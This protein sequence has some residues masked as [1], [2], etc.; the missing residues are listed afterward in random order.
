MLSRRYRRAPQ[1]RIFRIFFYAIAA[2]LLLDGLTILKH[3][4]EF[5]V[6]LLSHTYIEPSTLPTPAKDQKIFICA[7][8]WT[9]AYVIHTRWGDA[10]IDLIETLGADNV[11]VSIYE[12]GS[13]DNTKEILAYLDSRLAAKNIAR[14]ITLDPETHA[15]VIN[16]GPY[17]EKGDPRPGWVLP[18]SGSEGKEIR[19]IPYLA[20]TRNLSL[21]PLIEEKRR[22]RTYDKILFLN[23]IVF[24]PSDVVS[25]LA[26]NGG[27]YSVACALDFHYPARVATYYDTFALRDSNGDGTLSVQ[28]PYFRSTESRDAIWRGDSARVQSCWNG[29]TLMDATPFYNSVDG[30]GDSVDGLRFRGVSDSLASKHLE[31]SECCL[32]HADLTAMGAAEHGIY[33]NPAVRVGYTEEAYNFTHFGPENTFISPT[34]YVLAKWLYRLNRLRT[35]SAEKQMKTVHRRVEKWKKESSNSLEKRE[36]QGEMCLIDEMHLLIWN[37]WKHA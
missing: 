17:D 9:N 3:Y 20:K 6:N 2:L 15:D 31:G 13:L 24:K 7:Q 1:R 23:D 12:S 26:T 34:Q 37:G 10:L 36:E 16:A 30:K 33:V 25:L 21:Q 27:S 32:I 22:G 28:F 19:R 8:F 29:I 14:T 35:P 18:P 4:R 11:Y 5:A